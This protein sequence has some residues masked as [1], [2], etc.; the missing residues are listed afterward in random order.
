MGKGMDVD[1]DVVLGQP[2]SQLYWLFF[3]FFSMSTQHPKP[4]KL[5]DISQH[6]HLCGRQVLLFGPLS[7]TL[8]CQGMLRKYKHPVSK[9]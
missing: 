2:K 3:F 1:V 4:S 5:G 8:H 9:M 6:E 7:R